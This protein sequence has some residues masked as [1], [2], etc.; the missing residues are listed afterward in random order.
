[1]R[2]T[3]YLR[4]SQVDRGLAEGLTFYEQHLG[5]H[6]HPSWIAHDPDRVF[7][8][9][10]VVDQAQAALDEAQE[11]NQRSERKAHGL[12]L[13]ALDRGRRKD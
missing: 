4:W 3:K 9:D 6:G 2:P 5:P 10:E 7:E 12:Q 1:M 8:V 11:E 13:V